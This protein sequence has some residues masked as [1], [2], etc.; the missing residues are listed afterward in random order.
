MTYFGPDGA[1]YQSSIILK[2]A[3]WNLISYGAWR[4]IHQSGNK[5]ASFN[6]MMEQF[7]A[8]KIPFVAYVWV[9][10]MAPVTKAIHTAAAL[11][12]KSIPIMVDWEDPKCNFNRMAEY[13]DAMRKR[14]YRVT[15]L[16]TGKYFWQSMG[17]PDLT[18]LGVDLVVARYGNQSPT[19][20]YECEPRYTEMLPKYSVWNW[21][22][23]GLKP[24]MWQFGS[25]I[26][27]GTHYMDMN[28]ILDPAVISRSFKVW[29][30]IPTPIPVPTPVP[31][32][33]GRTDMVIIMKFGGTPTK[34]WGGYY[35]IDGGISR[36]PVRG[37]HH[38]GL[39]VALGAV[40][41]KDGHKVVNM[42][43]SDVS[44]TNDL[45]VLEETLTPGAD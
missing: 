16:Y 31:K 38:A 12:D 29:N 8:R 3:D 41:A 39:L 40:D 37:M 13:V 17:S 45:A 36:L 42:N 43:W 28:A 4:V 22:I 44:H 11:P 1:K 19:G 18:K 26:R 14:G 20:Q 33:K 21:N 34:D 35:S 24:S 32:L 15:L 9:D 23:G 27:W 2:P 6:P 30:P 25:R 7:K 10:A 5:D